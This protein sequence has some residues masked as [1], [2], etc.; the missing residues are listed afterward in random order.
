MVKCLWKLQRLTYVNLIK[1]K[2]IKEDHCNIMAKIES[3]GGKDLG[4]NARLIFIKK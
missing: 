2:K 1:F 4:E 3:I